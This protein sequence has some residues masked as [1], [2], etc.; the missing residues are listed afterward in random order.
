LIL[1]FIEG[2]R[3]KELSGFLGLPFSLP[4]LKSLSRRNLSSD[5]KS[6]EK[7]KL[8]FKIRAGASP[9]WSEQKTV[10]FWRYFV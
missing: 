6:R 3:A 2:L 8:F 10:V 9:H 7:E 4:P 5:E 1:S